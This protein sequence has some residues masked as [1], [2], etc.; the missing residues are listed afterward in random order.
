MP[1]FPPQPTRSLCRT[2]CGMR[3]VAGLKFRGMAIGVASINGLG[4][5]CRQP[6]EHTGNAEENF[7]G[8]LIP[9]KPMA[10][11]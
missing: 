3:H 2:S 8:D 6:R 7:N 1:S 10:K 4:N 11:G 5:F 9:L